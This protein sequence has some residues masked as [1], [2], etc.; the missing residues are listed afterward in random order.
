MTQFGQQLH[1]KELD[2]C[3]SLKFIDD[4]VS[5]GRMI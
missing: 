2:T 4:V 5:K 1:E 3:L